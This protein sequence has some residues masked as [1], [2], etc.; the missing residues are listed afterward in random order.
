[1]SAD[2]FSSMS[3]RARR[4]CTHMC[5]K[6]VEQLRL[7]ES[8]ASIEVDLQVNQ[9][10]GADLLRGVTK[11]RLEVSRLTRVMANRSPQGQGYVYAWSLSFHDMSSISTSS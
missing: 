1:M 8:C 2:A 5:C 6:L 3:D 10:Y 11:Q 4:S 7:H 9:D